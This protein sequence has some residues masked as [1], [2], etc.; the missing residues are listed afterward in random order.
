LRYH[1]DAYHFVRSALDRTQKTL[2]KRDNEGRRR[3]VT[4]QQLLDGI[5]ELALERFGPMAMAVFEEWGVRSCEDFGEIVFN[6]VEMQI[7]RKTEQDRRE[8]FR[9]A[10]TFSTLST[11][12]SF[13]VAAENVCGQIVQCRRGKETGL[14]FGIRD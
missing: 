8:D 11:G 10:M 1:R 12:L 3:D 9:A 7:L 2:L 4:G 13:P 5:R 6:L 14:V